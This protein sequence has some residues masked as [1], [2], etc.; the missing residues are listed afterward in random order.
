M[1]TVPLTPTEER[2]AL[3]VLLTVIY[4]MIAGFGLV[5]PLLP[6]FAQAFKASPLLVTAMFSAFSV[7]QFLGEPYWGKLS[8]RI[9]RRPVLIITITGVAL[10]YAALAFAPN[11]WVA[12]LI[13]FANG[14]M[15]GNISTL[16]GVL[17]DITPPEKRAG[18][19]GI[20]GAAFSAGFTTGPAIG[21]YL[22]Q[23]SRGALGFQL[24]LLAAAAFAGLSV[25]A[26]IFL[27]RETR[28]PAEPSAIRQVRSARLT[29]GFGHPVI[30]RVVMISFIVVIGFA[31]IEATYGLW[32]EKRFGWGPRQI[33]TA[34]ALIGILGAVC[35][36]W[37]CGRLARRYGEAP[38]LT[39]GL[40]LM[41]IGISTQGLSP[42]WPVAIVGF[43]FVCVGQ[44]LCFPNVSALISR[45]SPPDRQGEM[46]GLN[47]SGMALARIGGP[48]LAGWLFVIATG[49]PFALSAL[50][51]LPA[52]WF[53][54]SVIG[55]VP[56][57][58]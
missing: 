1:S 8:D 10:S 44:S 53:A 35:Q 5:I 7:G 37:L 40:V 39:A 20:M 46:L 50:L 48:M 27:V 13:R 26:V 14:I 34:F 57:L 12:L 25:L 43:A 52:L 21:G 30:S 9:G 18:R 56:R 17:A 33:A 49:A 31:G 11:I 16:Q 23:P 32:T 36:G 15:A 6:F 41:L 55:K 45:S 3:I 42:T 51:I 28:A 47:M 29:E 38:T 4:F 2:R 22:A 24:P 54:F 58:A 19:M